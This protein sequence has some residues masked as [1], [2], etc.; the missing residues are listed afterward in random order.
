MVGS[1]VLYAG[2]AHP[3]DLDVENCEREDVA[4][5]T[6]RQDRFVSMAA[7]NGNAVLP[8]CIQSKTEHSLIA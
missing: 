4:N 1:T 3:S 8:L 7:I 6:T 5:L 2:Q